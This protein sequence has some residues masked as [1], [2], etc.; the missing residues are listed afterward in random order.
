MSRQYDFFEVQA[1]LVARFGSDIPARGVLHTTPCTLKDG[2]LFIDTYGRGCTHNSDLNPYRKSLKRAG[3]W[4]SPMPF[5]ADLNVVFEYLNNGDYDRIV[6]GHK[7]E[8]FPWMDSKY[9]ISKTIMRLVSQ[10]S[11]CPVQINTSS[12]LVGRD[13]YRDVLR[14][15]Q[16]RLTINMRTEYSRTTF[17]K[18]QIMKS[19]GRDV[20]PTLANIDQ[21]IRCIEP[22]APSLKRRQDACT[23]LTDHGFRIKHV[24]LKHYPK[25]KAA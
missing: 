9:E 18:F 6:I 10:L 3:L 20:G 24:S 17:T 7:S 16:G 14:P 5:P 15:I 2:A 4:N 8:P 13:D 19:L 21:I 25:T 23:R 12:D 11:T 1:M 22:G